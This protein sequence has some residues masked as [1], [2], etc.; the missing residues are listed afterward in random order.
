MN[1]PGLRR[2]A[3]Y[4]ALASWLLEASVLSAILPLVDLAITSTNVNWRVWLPFGVL[5]LT[6]GLAGVYLKSREA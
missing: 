1:D 2:K 4:E 5:A 6:T 3:A